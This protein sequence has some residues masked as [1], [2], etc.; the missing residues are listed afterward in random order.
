MI[1]INKFIK[2]II[3]LMKSLPKIELNLEMEVNTVEL[4]RADNSTLKFET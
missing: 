1:E 3:F 2:L 4:K